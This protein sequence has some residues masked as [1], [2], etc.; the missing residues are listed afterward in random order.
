M[1]LWVT[2]AT[3]EDIILCKKDVNCVLVKLTTTSLLLL[4][5]SLV[6]LLVPHLDTD[7]ASIHPTSALLISRSTSPPFR[8]LYLTV[9]LTQAQRVGIERGRVVELNLP[10]SPF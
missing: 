3:D 10:L 6:L 8:L 4:L 9:T 2:K 5:L 1:V 7:T